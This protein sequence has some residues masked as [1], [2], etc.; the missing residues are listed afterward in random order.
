VLVL[1]AD[2]ILLGQVDQVDDWLGGE[3]EDWVDDLDLLIGLACVPQTLIQQFETRFILSAHVSSLRAI[4][5]AS[6]SW[7]KFLVF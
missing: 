3:E 7:V 1:L 6:T 2:V 4:F 5:V